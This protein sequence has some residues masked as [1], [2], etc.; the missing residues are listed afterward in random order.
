M[1]MDDAIADLR[2][3]ITEVSPSA[4]IEVE[5]TADDSATIRVH[6]PAEDEDRIKAVTTELTVALLTADGLDVQVLVYDG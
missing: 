4:R 1:T 2:V 3:R 5:R 6:A